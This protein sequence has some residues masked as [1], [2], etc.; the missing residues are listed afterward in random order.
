[1]RH[2]GRNENGVARLDDPRDAVSDA[3][4]VS[5][6]FG[7]CRRFRIDELTVRGQRRLAR[8]NQIEIGLLAVGG[9]AFFS[10]GLAPK[11]EV[12]GAAFEHPLA[13]QLALHHFLKA[14]LHVG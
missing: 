3:A 12:E 6:T 7:P 14:G 4:A 9:R 8:L 1:V 11:V 5:V 13:F 10:S 2:A